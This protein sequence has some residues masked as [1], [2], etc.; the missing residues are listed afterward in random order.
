MRICFYLS[1]HRFMSVLQEVHEEDPELFGAGTKV[2]MDAQ[3]F[4]GSHLEIQLQKKKGIYSCS[5]IPQKYIKTNKWI[6][7]C[8]NTVINF[9]KLQ[10]G[11]KMINMVITDSDS[12]AFLIL[13]GN[14]CHLQLQ[15]N[16]KYP[17]EHIQQ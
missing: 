9:V 17:N 14:I 15:P 7:D 12:E 13:R 3:C 10:V 11:K 2:M 5:S 16:T 4:C 1:A 8:I 6:K